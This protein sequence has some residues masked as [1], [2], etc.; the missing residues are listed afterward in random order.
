MR[1]RNFA[2]GLADIRTGRPF[3]DRLED[4]YWAYDRGRLFG[5]IAPISMPLRIGKALNPKAVA[6][7]NAAVEVKWIV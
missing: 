4:K 6:L 1:H 7:Y 3:D 5:A 2:R